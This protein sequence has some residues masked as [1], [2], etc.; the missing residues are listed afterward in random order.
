VLAV[1]P[2]AARNENHLPEKLRRRKKV[3]ARFL[4]KLQT[5]KAKKSKQEWPDSP[6]TPVP[7]TSGN[8]FRRLR[9]V[10][11]PESEGRVRQRLMEAHDWDSGFLESVVQLETAVGRRLASGLPK[12]Q[13][14]QWLC[15]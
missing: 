13:K 2:P 11:T 3:Q 9:G 8:P 15:L 10:P 7:R 14:R 4:S 5:R 12:E 6:H 1:P